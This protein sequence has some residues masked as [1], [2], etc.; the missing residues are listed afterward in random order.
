MLFVASRYFDTAVP[1]IPIRRTNM[2]SEQ[3]AWLL[4]YI[5]DSSMLTSDDRDFLVMMWVENWHMDAVFD[6]WAGHKA[7]VERQIKRCGE[8]GIPLNELN[9]CTS[10][11]EQYKQVDDAMIGC[12]RE[13]FRPNKG[14][15]K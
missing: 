9:A 4:N 15:R 10:Y 6:G 5:E 11:L 7:I 12:V 3:R 8:H 14:S 13:L 1:K 2:T